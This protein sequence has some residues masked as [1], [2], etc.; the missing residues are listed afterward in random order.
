MCRQVQAMF[1]PKVFPQIYKRPTKIQRV[2]VIEWFH[3]V[4]L[5]GSPS[6][7]RKFE[8][9]SSRYPPCHFALY[10]E[11]RPL[12]PVERLSA[13]L[14]RPGVG[15]ARVAVGEGGC[16]RAMPRLNALNRD[17]LVFGRVRA[18]AG[19]CTI[20][21]FGG[22]GKT[23]GSTPVSATETCDRISTDKGFVVGFMYIPSFPSGGQQ[24]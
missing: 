22:I 10:F 11:P 19:V 7:G 6:L 16:V 5:F 1:N 2:W 15:G 9:D 17:L 21:G 23:K 18:S 12:L 24:N 14:D 3:G 20:C 8:C 4:R 13:D